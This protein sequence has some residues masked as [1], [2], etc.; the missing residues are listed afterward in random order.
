MDRDVKTPVKSGP[1]KR[2]SGLTLFKPV[3]GAKQ[4]QQQFSLP[5]II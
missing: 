4:Q 1:L 5:K 3:P 2:N